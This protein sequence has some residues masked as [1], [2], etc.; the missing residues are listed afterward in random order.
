MSED[1]V[2]YHANNSKNTYSFKIE[3]DLWE[4]RTFE[5]AQMILSASVQNP[6]HLEEIKNFAQGV[7]TLEQKEIDESFGYH[8]D[9]GQM[10]IEILSHNAITLAKKFIERYR[11]INE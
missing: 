2:K 1:P 6:S 11:Q 5:T 4:K 3:E 8:V 7:E 9:K 10:V